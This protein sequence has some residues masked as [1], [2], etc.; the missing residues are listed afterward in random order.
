[1]NPD[2][3][4]VLIALMLSAAVLSAAFMLSW[5]AFGEK[6][7][8]FSW[9]I[10]FFAATCQ[11]FF[12]LT[13]SWFA[14]HQTYWL[15]V[16]AFAAL[17]VTMGLKGHIERSGKEFLRGGSLLLGL[18]V[19]SFVVW[20]TVVDPHLGSSTAAIPLFAGIGLLASAR[21]IYCP[22]RNKR[23]SEHAVAVAM[24]IVGVAQFA[25]AYFAYGQGPDGNVIYRD[26]YFH[27]TFLSLPAGYV[28][29]G[30]LLVIIL[31][32]DHVNDIDA[33]A[34]VDDTTRV[35][36]LD[37]FRRAADLQ[38]KEAL[39]SSTPLSLILTDFDNLR[40]LNERYGRLSG[41]VALHEFAAF[42]VASST[43]TAIVARIG[44]NKFAVLLPGVASADA[45][46]HGENIQQ[47]LESTQI[48]LNGIPVSMTANFGVASLSANDAQISDV[49]A[50]AEQAL[51][52]SQRSGY[53]RVDL[54]SSSILRR[55]TDAFPLVPT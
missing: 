45:T 17:T 55:G 21:L 23:L 29:M 10:A 5:S 42:L 18:P 35:L 37:G 48:T 38:F 52:R 15:T 9:S 36:N 12:S 27:I 50:R 1:M 44:G 43:Q 41:D 26:L 24:V 3:A 53:N 40:Q 49:I 7:H 51:V 30:V 13:S 11:W 47:L 20:T 2:I 16:S 32:E 6:P 14:S 19:F 22:A 46:C 34:R 31:C 39:R 54:E 25:A 28:V 33:T 8:A 4:Y